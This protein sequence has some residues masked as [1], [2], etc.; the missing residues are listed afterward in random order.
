MEREREG[1][2]E[3]EGRERERE[4]GG[5][6]E[7]ER[8]EGERESCTIPDTYTVS[9]IIMGHDHKLSFFNYRIISS[10]QSGIFVQVPNE[11]G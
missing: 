1:G 5:G 9:S 11:I 10:F 7:G 3:R 6:G 2:R 8:E 4:E